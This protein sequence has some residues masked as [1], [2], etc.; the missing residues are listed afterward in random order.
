[1]QKDCSRKPRE[2]LWYR[3]RPREPEVDF[4]GEYVFQIPI[5]DALSPI[6][7][8]QATWN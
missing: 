3:P 6:L 5:E 2:D 4:D 8:Y 7:H 1:M